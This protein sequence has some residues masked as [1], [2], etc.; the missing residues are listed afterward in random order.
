MPEKDLDNPAF[1]GVPITT[2]AEYQADCQECDISQFGPSGMKEMKRS[3]NYTTGGRASPDWN[4]HS[5]GIVRE[6]RGSIPLVAAA[7]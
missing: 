4:G 2:G 5:D 6:G 1:P 7:S 3:G